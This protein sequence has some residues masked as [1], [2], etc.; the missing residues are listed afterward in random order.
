VL[1]VA[2]DD[3]HVEPAVLSPTN[4]TVWE[5]LA[6]AS[7]HLFEDLIEPE[8]DYELVVA[9][10][11]MPANTDTRHYHGLT[12]NIFRYTPSVAGGVNIH[13]IDEYIE[14]DSHLQI[15]AFFYEYLQ[16]IDT[17]DAEN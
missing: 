6:G 11:V 1:T 12:K 13:S 4:D 10:M 3:N 17:K 5:Y 14:F 15:I 2:I 7:R 9:P 8:A 16:V